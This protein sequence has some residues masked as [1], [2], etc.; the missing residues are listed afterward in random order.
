MK[1]EALGRGWYKMADGTKVRMNKEEAD[2]YR[3]QLVTRSGKFSAKKHN[4]V[5]HNEA[6]EMTPA[7]QKYWV[8]H[9]DTKLVIIHCIE[10]GKARYVKVQ[11]QFQV[12]RCIK[13]T[14]KYRKDLRR[15][16]RAEKRA[17]AKAE[18]QA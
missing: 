1:I 11:D 4:E 16:K 2:K 15:M 12:C 7:L 6:A 3:H 5:E 8:N 18:A 13:C 10:C 9:P 17:L 14:D